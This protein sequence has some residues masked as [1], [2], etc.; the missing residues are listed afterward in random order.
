MRNLAVGQSL[1]ARIHFHNQST[2]T[3]TPAQS[4]PDP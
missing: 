4:I 3:Q 1:L 2:F